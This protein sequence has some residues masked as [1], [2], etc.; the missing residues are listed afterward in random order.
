MLFRQLFDREFSTYTYLFADPN[1]KEAI[2]IDPT[3]NCLERDLKLL[4]ELGLTL[5]YCLETHIHSDHLTGTARLRQKTG[6]LGVVPA[7]AK[8]TYADRYLGKNETLQL[9]SVWIQAIA[10]PGHTA[11]HNVYLINHDYLLTG[12]ALLIRGC[13]RTDLQGGDA[14]ELYNSISQKLFTLPDDTQVYPG[15]DYHGYT[16]STIG[17]ERRFNPQFY[18]RNREEF[19]DFMARLKLPNTKMIM[20]AVSANEMSKLKPMSKAKNANK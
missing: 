5:K 17:G 1:V 13:G 10:T 16:V 7:G 11:H 19:V 9:G 4:Q 8:A 2:L 20:E 6:C 12:D 15:H 14:G 18:N 3:F